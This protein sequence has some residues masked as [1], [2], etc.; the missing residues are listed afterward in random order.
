MPAFLLWLSW[1]HRRT[2]AEIFTVAVIVSIVVGGSWTGAMAM[3]DYWFGSTHDESAALFV[4]VDQVEW[5]WLGGLTDTE[6]TVVVGPAEEATELMVVATPT[7]G[8][9]AIRSAS[10]TMVG[11]PTARL[12][13][14][15]LETDTEYRFVVEVDGEAD[16]GRGQGS[17][18]TAPAGASSFH[19]AFSSCARTDSNGA[20]FDAIAGEDPL[21]FLLLGDI[22]YANLESSDPT[23]HRTA[24]TRQLTR[25]GQAALYRQVPIAY[26]WDDHD[27]GPNDADATSPTRPAA[28]QAYREMVPHYDL[29][30]E[31][32]SA[33]HQ[34]FTVGRVRFILTDSRSERTDATMLG[35]QQLEWLIEEVTAASE[36][37][38]LVVWGNAVPWIGNSTEGGD[39]WNGYASERGQ[40]ADA[41]AEA[42]VQ[43]L[44]ML[45]GDAHMVAFDDGTNSDY[46]TDKV[47]GF[48][49]MHAAPLDRRGNEKGGPYSHPTF[50]GSGQYGT[51]EVVDEGGDEILVRLTGRTSDG[52]TLM[53]EE[54]SFAAGA[55]S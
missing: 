39:N 31:G 28:R 48:P 7:A 50:P 19:F 15:G 36:T 46:S 22:H 45:S 8:G 52:E 18:T 29:V 25:P 4:A 2:M 40:I 33:I 21:F 34:A 44:L 38:A 11:Q 43:N 54:L 6:V 16:S 35:A 13:L 3:H 32:D 5:V 24:L 23:D 41:M 17:F 47:G 30:E 49:I 27:Y 37:H 1:Q 26:V 42:D 51:V 20:V 9:A 55:E 53:A 12:Y 10:V 14:S